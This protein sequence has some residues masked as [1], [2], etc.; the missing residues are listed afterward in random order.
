MYKINSFF[1]NDVYDELSLNDEP[2]TLYA[3]MNS[4]INYN[5]PNPVKIE[6]LPS[7]F[8]GY[9]FDFDYP[10]NNE[11]KENFEI[12]F[13][14]HY[15]ERRIGFPTYLSFKLHLKSKMWEIMPKYNKML[16]GFSKLDFDGE[17]EIETR[18]ENEN[19]TA[20]THSVNDNRFSNTPQNELDDIQ[21]GGYATDYTYNVG[22]GNN[23]ANRTTNENIVRTKIDTIDEYKKYIE[24]ANNVYTL[25]FKECDNLF[26]SVV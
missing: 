2:P 19:G 17:K 25:I 9:L 11:F 20:T 22:D 23:S 7:A 3:L 6:N 24:N 21:D 16:E 10:L 1:N 13:L 12:A 15:M 18:S 26:F 4:K 8:R 5:N 14:T